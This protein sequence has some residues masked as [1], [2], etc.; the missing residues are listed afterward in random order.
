MRKNRSHPWLGGFMRL[1]ITIQM[2]LRMGLFST[3]ILQACS[4]PVGPDLI[5]EPPR[6]E[7]TDPKGPVPT[8]TPNPRDDD[9]VS[10]DVNQ[11]LNDA[12]A[13]C[14][15]EASKA[16]N[17]G[18]V[19]DVSAMRSGKY[20]IVA[21]K[22]EESKL[23]QRI[24][25]GSMPPGKRLSEKQ[26]QAVGKW[27][28][29]MNGRTGQ[30]ISVLSTV[31]Q[32]R[33]DIEKSE[34][35]ATLKNVRY[36][37]LYSQSAISTEEKT[38]E[39]YR[40]AF[41]K[42]I[43]SISK[44]AKLILP[45][46]VDAQKL[47][48]AVDVVELGF[49]ASE[50][51]EIIKKYNPFCRAPGEFFADDK[52][53]KDDE[54][55]KEKL[56]SECPNIRL[57]WFTATA[58]LPKPYADFMRHPTT[59][60][61]LDRNLGVNLIEDINNGDVQRSGV[62]NSGVSSQ[63]RIVERHV[64]SSGQP[65]WISYD[66]AENTGRG[67]IFNNPLGPVGITVDGNVLAKESPNTFEH[68]GGEVIYQL[69]NG[70]FGYYLAL[71]DEQ[72]T[73]IDKGPRA[74]VTQS[75]APAVFSS[76]IVNGVSCMSC[77]GGGLI[78]KEDEVRKFVDEDISNRFSAA[79][80]AKVEQLYV[81]AKTY[82]NLIESDNQR[83]FEALR[84]I[85]VTPGKEDPVNDAFRLYNERMAIPS[86]L[87]ELQLPKDIFEPLLLLSDLATQ[88]LTLKNA[89]GFISRDTFQQGLM[90]LARTPE[91]QDYL[92]KPKVGDFVITRACMAKDEV[93]MDD[94][95]IKPS[96]GLVRQLSLT[97]LPAK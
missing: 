91:S 69:P 47:I 70:L 85:G 86:V 6:V 54:F 2:L 37:S 93:R 49:K 95:F 33:A 24:K 63:N 13:Q 31:Q 42:V 16:G 60:A 89:G 34:S 9:V 8:A 27:I 75:G 23:Y 80:K 45:R 73:S 22:P 40:K 71:G 3:V 35:P 50:F 87:S 58:P 94:C 10:V 55:V 66:F 44:N 97:P 62:K 83:Y 96:P 57:D 32:I 52:F 25:D 5:I 12:C 81:D 77:H 36:F 72:G 76:S 28:S 64:Q 65:Y 79:E 92:I 74:I 53:K 15:N 39:T 20:Y 46:A 26:V 21:G 61:E 68:D 78:H 18:L 19:G 4:Q 41:V 67:D 29:E 48:Y 14:H 82:K 17:F 43:N 7:I 30:E 84:T 90:S 38:L 56:V 59:R 88:W 11:L 1:R 51:D